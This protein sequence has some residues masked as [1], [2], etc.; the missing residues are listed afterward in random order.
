LKDSTYF[1]ISCIGG[2][3]TIG[4]ADD[5][6]EDKSCTSSTAACREGKCDGRKNKTSRKLNESMEEEEEKKQYFHPTQTWS[7]IQINTEHF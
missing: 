3:E 6:H 4:L 5:T 2:G 1:L 7:S